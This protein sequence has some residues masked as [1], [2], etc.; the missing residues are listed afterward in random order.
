MAL[1]QAFKE[2]ISPSLERC[3]RRLMV[4]SSIAGEFVLTIELS[5]A[6]GKT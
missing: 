6:H 4:A 2:R 5:G 3:F 1:D